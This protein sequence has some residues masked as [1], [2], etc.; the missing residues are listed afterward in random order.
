MS[1]LGKL[2]LERS[3]A[4][5]HPR[6]LIYEQNCPERAQIIQ[7][8]RHI[9]D[10]MIRIRR[11][12]MD[13]ITIE[14]SNKLAITHMDITFDGKYKSPLSSFPRSFLVE[15]TATSTGQ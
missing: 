9:I 15:D 14:I 5:S 2:F 3:R 6:F 10:D 7:V 11:F 4:G 1:E 8:T 12:N 13:Q